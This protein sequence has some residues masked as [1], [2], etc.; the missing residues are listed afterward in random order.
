MYGVFIE[1]FPS[2]LSEAEFGLENETGYTV[3]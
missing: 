2:A 3:R 1:V